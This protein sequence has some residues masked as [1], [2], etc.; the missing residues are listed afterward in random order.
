[1]RQPPPPPPQPID[2]ALQH[3]RQVNIMFVYTF[4]F[5]S[6]TLILPNYASTLF[7]PL[8]AQYLNGLFLK[9]KTTWQAQ[10]HP[11]LR[12]LLCQW[13]QTHLA[14]FI[15]NHDQQITPENTEV[16]ANCLKL[17][18]DLE[19]LIAR[20]KQAPHPY[21]HLKGVPWRDDADPEYPLTDF[22]V[23]QYNACMDE[24]AKIKPTSST[25]L[26]QLESTQKILIILSFALD[27][28]PPVNPRIRMPISL[29]VR[30]LQWHLGIMPVFYDL[31][32]LAFI[33]HANKIDTICDENGACNKFFTNF[34]SYT[35]LG[36]NGPYTNETGTSNGIIT[37]QID[38]MDEYIFE[39]HPN[40]NPHFNTDNLTIFKCEPTLMA[41]LLRHDLL[42]YIPPWY[43]DKLDPNPLT[44][45]H[46]G[47]GSYQGIQNYYRPAYFR[48]DD[49]AHWN[50]NDIMGINMRKRPYNKNYN[51]YPLP[52]SATN[53]NGFA[54]YRL[55]THAQ[56]NRPLTLPNIPH[57]NRPA[58]PPNY[59]HY[60]PFAI[61]TPSILTQAMQSSSEEEEEEEEANGEEEAHPSSSPP[62]PPPKPPQ[63]PYRRPIDEYKTPHCCYI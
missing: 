22:V 52:V 34:N 51:P 60:N 18:S 23:F 2:K 11:D 21:S 12:P 14:F 16:K 1:M 25:I 4:D 56:T 45:A 3:I 54:N 13:L 8:L 33:V 20:I 29:D 59:P 15:H 50:N 43:E 27:P 58:T 46:I 5:L 9:I 26:E 35:V 7:M 57:V 53:P 41:L 62:F 55:S 48:K 61:P 6:D 42:D 39:Q 38:H 44:Q 30:C 19:Q 17:E 31:Y 36:H 40:F 24:I 10:C 32:Q 63:N 28:D 47:N 49:P 37:E